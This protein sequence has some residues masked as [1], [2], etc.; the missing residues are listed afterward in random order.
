MQ[1]RRRELRAALNAELA[2]GRNL[3]R[4]SMLPPQRRCRRP[5]QAHDLTV[6]RPRK[7][8]AGVVVGCPQ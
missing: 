7:E 5:L 2:A 1:Q 4:R 8:W 6:G 3:V